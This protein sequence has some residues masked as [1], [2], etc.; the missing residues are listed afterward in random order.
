MVAPT[1]QVDLEYTEQSPKIK[2][3]DPL[4]PSMIHRALTARNRVANVA[5]TDFL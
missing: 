4:V 2:R 1:S 3:D 5:R